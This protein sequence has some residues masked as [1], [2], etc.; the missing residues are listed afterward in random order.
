[1][2]TP[3]YE[4]RIQP[5]KVYYQKNIFT[6]CLTTLLE[7]INYDIVLYL[8]SLLRFPEKEKDSVILPSVTTL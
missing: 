1:M 4:G 7:C 8:R 6:T 3:F 5:E 2:N